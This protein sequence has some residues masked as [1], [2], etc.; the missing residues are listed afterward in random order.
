MK[1]RCSTTSNTA[2]PWRKNTVGFCLIEDKLHTTSVFLFLILTLLYWH[3]LISR[4]QG[5]L[6]KVASLGLHPHH[7]AHASRK[8][9]PDASQAMGCLA[10]HVPVCHRH[11][12]AIF[13]YAV[14]EVEGG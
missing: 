12:A 6:A 7:S 8:K 1:E 3:L 4:M 9:K 10:D 2:P 14:Q 5:S 13:K 11:V